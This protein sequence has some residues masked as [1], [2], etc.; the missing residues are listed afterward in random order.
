MISILVG[1]AMILIGFLMMRKA[2]KIGNKR[3]EY[4][5]IFAILAGIGVLFIVLT[6]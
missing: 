6:T 1:L 3:M 4:Y 5:S 2:N